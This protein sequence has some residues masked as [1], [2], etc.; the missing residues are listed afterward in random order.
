MLRQS[1]SSLKS[2]LLGTSLAL[3]LVG[4]AAD[5]DAPAP[6][7]QDGQVQNE[8]VSARDIADLPA[9]EHLRVN[10][11]DDVVYFFDYSDPI[12][13]ARVDVTVGDVTFSLEEHILNL[14]SFDYDP[15]PPVDLTESPNNQFRMATDPADIGG[16]TE[17]EIAVLKENGYLYKELTQPGVQP[18]TTGGDCIQAICETC[19]PPPGAD[20][21]DWSPANPCVC[22]YEV[23]EWCD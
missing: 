8:L 11:A 3:A 20:S 19:G 16:L 12:D 1:L 10:L 22:T 2:L 4:C 23:H 14:Q 15:Y 17:G 5:P 6:P 21:C 9:G 18:Q 13:F 7:D